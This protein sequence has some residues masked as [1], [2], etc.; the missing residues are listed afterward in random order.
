MQIITIEQRCQLA[1]QLAAS[2]LS[3]LYLSR[4]EVATL[5]GT[6]RRA[7]EQLADKGRGPTPLRIGRRT[8]RY[9]AADVFSWLESLSKV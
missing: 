3:N 5:T 9:K 8:V 4:E 2:D 1:N 6:T 7:L